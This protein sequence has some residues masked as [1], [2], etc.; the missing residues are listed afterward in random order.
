MIAWPFKQLVQIIV[1]YVVAL[2]VGI[3]FVSLAH[4]FIISA[5]SNSFFSQTMILPLFLLMMPSV[6]VWHLIA[7][8]SPIMRRYKR[9]VEIKSASI[10]VV[11]VLVGIVV[12]LPELAPAATI[13]ITLYVSTFTIAAGLCGFIMDWLKTKEWMLCR[14]II[15]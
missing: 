8:F 14:F 3:V 2:L 9:Y 6:L 10:T 4:L 5:L 15:T 12:W 7:Q 1:R 11:L 13:D